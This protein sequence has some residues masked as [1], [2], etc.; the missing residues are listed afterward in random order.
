MPTERLTIAHDRRAYMAH[1]VDHQTYYEQFVTPRVE[2][3]VSDVIGRDRILAS[4]DPYLNDIPLSRWDNLANGT[5]HW[6]LEWLSVS[7]SNAS[8]TKGGTP[9][10]SLAD[11][12]CV[13]KAAAR[14]II[15][16]AA[17]A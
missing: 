2:Q 9:W 3:T 8:T 11:R 12:V 16:E 10:H 13:L 15:R 6:S 5:S 14:K 1:E 7:D 4:T 17:Q